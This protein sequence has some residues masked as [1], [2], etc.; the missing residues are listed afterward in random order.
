VTGAEERARTA[1][2][3]LRSVLTKLAD[4]TGDRAKILR[5]AAR[6]AAYVLTVTAQPSELGEKDLSQELLEKL[7]RHPDP[8]TAHLSQWT[9][10]FR[11]APDG[12]VRPLLAAAEHAKYDDDVPR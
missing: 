7:S 10:S 3:T 1:R 8:V 2:E 6:A 5:R 12:T 9:L 4:M 11:F